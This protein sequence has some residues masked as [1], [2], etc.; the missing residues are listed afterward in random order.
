MKKKVLEK[1][2]NPHP[3]E[4]PNTLAYMN[5]TRPVISKQSSNIIIP[6]VQNAWVCES[7]RRKKKKKKRVE[8]SIPAAAMQGLVKK[9]SMQGLVKKPKKK[10]RRKRRRRRRNSDSEDFIH[11]ESSSRFD[12]SISRSCDA[13]SYTSCSLSEPRSELLN[14]QTDHSMYST[15][16]FVPAQLGFQAPQAIPLMSQISQVRGASTD[17]YHSLPMPI[18]LPRMSKKK[19]PI[20][21]PRAK[22]SHEIYARSLANN[23]SMHF[24]IHE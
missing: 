12:P 1:F 23:P 13:Y 2:S 21:L 9:P 16:G 8:E 22:T 11:T 5:S 3:M 7:P 17:S 20:E 15:K 4:T 6:G 24:Q 14:L 19:E 18:E 10:K